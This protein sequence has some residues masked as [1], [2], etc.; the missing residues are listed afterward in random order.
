MR[1]V[2]PLSR[3]RARVLCLVCAV[4]AT[5]FA[6]HAHDGILAPR[7][8]AVL[9]FFGLLSLNF[10]VFS[11]NLLLSARTWRRARSEQELEN[12]ATP[13]MRGELTAVG[14][15]TVLA[16]TWLLAASVGILLGAIAAAILQHFR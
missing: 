13:A 1:Y 14:P 5:G 4:V 6:F 12:I 16:A 9:G 11:L 3:K 7:R 15:R 2:S 8:L 10:A